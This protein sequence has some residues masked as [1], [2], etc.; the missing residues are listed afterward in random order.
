[1]PDALDSLKAL[2]I[3]MSERMGIHSRE[4]DLRTVDVV[5]K[6]LSR[7]ADRI[8]GTTGNEGRHDSA[9]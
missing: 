6:R 3:E 1:M 8:S 5:S 9:N 2:V 4:S 7:R